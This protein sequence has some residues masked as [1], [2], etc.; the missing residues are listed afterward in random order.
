MNKLWENIITAKSV[1][2]M[3]P[4]IVQGL[5]KDWSHPRRWCEENL[6]KG[7]WQYLGR[8]DFR[9]KYPRDAAAFTLRWT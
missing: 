1:L 7:D 5:V 4:A 3:E 8:G 9:F 2:S 6:V